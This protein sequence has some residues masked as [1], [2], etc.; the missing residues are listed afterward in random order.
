MN[1]IDIIGYIPATIFPVATIL[2]LLHMRK[3]QS[4]EGV[5]ALAWSAFALGNASLYVYTEKYFALQT[6]IGLLGTCILQIFIVVL[7]VK[8]RKVAPR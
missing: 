2:Q 5:S 4:S 7:I 8:Y 6:I 3:T 1:H